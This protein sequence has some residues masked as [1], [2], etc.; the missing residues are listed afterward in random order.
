VDVDAQK[1]DV[2]A[3]DVHAKSVRKSGL[4]MAR[5]GAAGREDNW[6]T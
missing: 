2:I 3:K 5:I 4:C 1:V 6:I